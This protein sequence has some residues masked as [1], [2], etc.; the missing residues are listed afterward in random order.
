MNDGDIL[1]S[2]DVTGLFTNVP[3]DETIKILVN[4][5]FTDNWFNKTYGLNWQED[6]L[7]RLLEI[8]TTN[9]L[10]QF[11]GQHYQQ[12]DGVAGY[13]LAPWSSTG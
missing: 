8:T 4:R 5:A 13:G 3:L 2:Y 12:T 1:V 10:F 9:H 7:A 6:Q 11:N